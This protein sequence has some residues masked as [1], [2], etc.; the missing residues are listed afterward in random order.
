[1]SD[2][3]NNTESGAGADSSPLPGSAFVVEVGFVDPQWRTTGWR[4]VARYND[5]RVAESCMKL[6]RHC[7]IR[8]REIEECEACYAARLGV[9]LD[10]ECECKPNIG[11]GKTDTTGNN[12]NP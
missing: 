6:N 2:D 5:S 4:E 12:A 10:A 11:I 1:M 8:V 3:V 9:S 7:E